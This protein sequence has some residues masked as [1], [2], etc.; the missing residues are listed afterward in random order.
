MLSVEP[1]TRFLASQSVKPSHLR[2]LA[3]IVLLMMLDGVDLQLLALTAP[4]IVDNWGITAG[5][6]APALTAALVGMTIGTVTG[7]WLGD[8][9]GRRPVILGSAILFGIMTLL[10]S[11]AWDTWSLTVIRLVAGC[12]FGALTPN[13]YSL[14]GEIFPTKLRARVMGLLAIGIPIGGVLGSGLAL[15]TVDLIGWRGCFAAVGALTLVLV[16]FALRMLPESPTYLITHKTEVSALKSLCRITTRDP[17]DVRAWIEGSH[18][19]QHPAAAEVTENGAPEED[20][21]GIFGSV[22]RRLTIG[23]SLS[24][25]ALFFITYGFLNWL[26]TLLKTAGLTMER[27]LEAS[28]ALSTMSTIGGLCVAVGLDRVGS[29]ATLIVGAL[30]SGGA[31]LFMPVL[32]P[33]AVDGSSRGTAG[34]FFAIGLVGFVL[35]YVGA[36]LYATVAVGYPVL[37][38][39]SGVGFTA[40]VARASGIVVTFSGGVLLAAS[41]HGVVFFGTLAFMSTLLL[42]GSLINNRHITAV[43]AAAT[44]S[45]VEVKASYRVP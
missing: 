30:I 8:R 14:S 20:A 25:F 36:T 7:G 31:L 43:N 33:L 13:V 17:E 44:K 41:D 40:A 1:V 37:Y 12:G 35:G 23:A 10:T 42:S 19:P 26:P 18:H 5:A 11:Q 45:N 6:I 21:G 32:I 22:S 38:R 29:R 3:I 34:L 28:L 2:I 4:L 15:I 24:F 16:A 27:T 9:F 39:S